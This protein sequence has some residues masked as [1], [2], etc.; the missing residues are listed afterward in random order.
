MKYIDKIVKYLLAERLKNYNIQLP[1]VISRRIGKYH[2]DEHDSKRLCEQHFPTRIPK[3]D[4]RKRGKELLTGAN[5]VERLC[6]LCHVSKIY[7]TQT[8]Y[9]LHA[10]SFRQEILEVEGVENDDD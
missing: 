1:L 3:G 9:K 10:K 6:V 2:K 8:D 5:I 4:G 7:H